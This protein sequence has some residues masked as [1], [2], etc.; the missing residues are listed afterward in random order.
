MYIDKAHVIKDDYAFRPEQVA[1]F[2]LF[3]TELIIQPSC[4]IKERVRCG[5]HSIADHKGDR[6][7]TEFRP[8]KSD[9]LLRGESSG[10]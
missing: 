4:R 7:N 10:H 6:G 3:K 1:I 8:L 5:I 9:M 2:A